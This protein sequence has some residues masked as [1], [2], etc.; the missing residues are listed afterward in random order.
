MVVKKIDFKEFDIHIERLSSILDANAG[1]D[2][3]L[4]KLDAQGFECQILDGIDPNLAK[5][6]KAK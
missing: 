6:I 3:P 5:V 2:F 1:I 4:V